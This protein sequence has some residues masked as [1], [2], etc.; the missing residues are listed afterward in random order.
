MIANAAQNN[1][2]TGFTDPVFQS[3]AAFRAVLAA[4]A[5]PGTI[6]RLDTGF[7][8]PEG[9]EP[10]SAIV[11]LTLADFETPVW[12]DEPRRAGQAALWL[13][14][15][16]TVPLVTIPEAAGF[17]VLSGA[18]DAPRLD[19]FH[20]GTD[21]YPDRAATLLIECDALEGGEPVELSGPGIPDRRRISP[22][23]LRAGFW[24]E[25]RANHAHYPLGVDV[26]LVCGHAIMGLPRSSAAI[27]G[28]EALDS[29]RLSDGEV[30]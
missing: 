2:G 1:P 14:F 18:C 25:I 17:A 30:R 28:A 9:L 16:A 8:G 20:P 22:K 21:L 29:G 12:L 19:A 23:G 10:A 26:V 27:S 3:Q 7:A 24:D 15:H 11:L 5:E 4:L 13:R 6:H